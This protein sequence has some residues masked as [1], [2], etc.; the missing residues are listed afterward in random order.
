MCVWGG[1][2]GGGGGRE[3][4]RKR[5]RERGGMGECYKF[6]QIKFC[7]RIAKTDKT[8]IERITVICNS[9]LVLLSLVFE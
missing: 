6:K 3:K 2:G 5:E 9:K 1:G 4:K 8:T 7:F